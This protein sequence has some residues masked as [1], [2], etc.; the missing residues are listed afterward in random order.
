MID[1]SIDRESYS[2]IQKMNPS[3]LVAGLKSMKR[4]ARQIK[5]GFGETT[6]AMIFG[7]RLHV[8][9]LEPEEF[10][11]QFVVMP[12]FHLDPEN[13]TQNGKRSYMTTTSYCEE[14]RKQ[15]L[16]ENK[17]R[18]VVK[19]QDYDSMLYAIESMRSRPKI[20]ELLE[21][22]KKEVTVF[23]SIDGIECKGR[24]DLL[25]DDF[26]TD[27][28]TTADV[29]PKLFARTFV[30]M[31][32]GFKLAMYREL[33]RQNT[34]EKAVKVIAQE[35]S[36]DFDTVLFDVPDFV[37]DI[38]L[39]KVRSVIA[40]YKHALETG[41]WSGVDRGMDELALMLPKYALDEEEKVLDWSGVDTVSESAAVEQVF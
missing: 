36:G 22:S 34:N 13:K 15:F 37:L 6:D 40:D 32:Y 5:E 27:L 25:S 9:L 35:V 2:K 33:V 18:E 20:V 7:T 23:G 3:T 16:E 19:R 24:I 12:D 41:V 17:G 39:N 21:S 38:G 30:N 26:I 11:S 28:K 4:L 10:E 29:E 1:D 14:K 31:G 8:L